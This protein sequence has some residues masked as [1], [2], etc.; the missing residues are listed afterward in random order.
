MFRTLTVTAL[1]AYASAQSLSQQCT[2]TLA[3]IAGNPD[4][5]SCLSPGSL[6]SIVAGG[7]SNSIVASIDGWL[8]NICGAPACSNDTL[9]AVVKNATE[10]C[11]TELS[12]LGFN[13]N[14]TP[15]ITGLVQQYY[16]T[17][18]KV[19][20]LKDGDSNC[21]TKT[22][23][24]VEATFGTL[25]LQNIIKIVT[26]PPDD[27]PANITCTNCVKAAYNVIA[28]DVPGLVSDTSAGLQ[29][30]CGADFTDG[31]TPT[32]ISQSA[33]TNVASS[34]STSNGAALSTLTSL[35]G[36]IVGGLAVSGL[37]AVASAFTLLA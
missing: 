21:I 4:A 10:G 14:L 13:S 33:N 32:G 28:Q 25:N 22:L 19:V 15:T 29:Q 17:V 36:G 11:S 16:P 24:D 31:Q 35:N 1:I 27:L 6:V 37:V 7:S 18:R 12:G 9:A 5:A 8:S 23:G 34:P 20:C 26:N 2:A 3:A 30:Q